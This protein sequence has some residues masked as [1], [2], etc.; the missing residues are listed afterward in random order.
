MGDEYNELLIALTGL[1]EKRTMPETAVRLFGKDR[2]EEWHPDGWMKSRI[3]R[4]RRKAKRFLKERTDYR[5]MA[6]RPG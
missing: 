3:Q 4:L 2:A 1:H 5:A 6:A